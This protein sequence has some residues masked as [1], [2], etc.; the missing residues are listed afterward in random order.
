MVWTDTGAGKIRRANLD[1]STVEDLLT[2]GRSQRAPTTIA[3]TT[4]VV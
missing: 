4:K 2:A 1:G 3:T